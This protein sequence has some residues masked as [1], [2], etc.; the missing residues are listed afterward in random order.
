[1]RKTSLSN[2]EPALLLSSDSLSRSVTCLDAFPAFQIPTGSLNVAFLNPADCRSLHERFFADPS[3]TD[4]MTFPGDPEDDHAGDIAICPTVASHS[5]PEHGLSFQGELSLYLVHG[6]LH[7]AGLEDRTRDGRI[8]M[9]AA[10]ASLM[11]HLRAAD[12]L[13]DAR[14]KP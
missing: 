1:M 10:E 9:R 11:E 8:A 6:W 12:G 14:W 7:L 5:G 13:L 3:V 2:S 4:V